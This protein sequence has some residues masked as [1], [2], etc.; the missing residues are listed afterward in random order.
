[1]E[2]HILRGVLRGG[3]NK[4][5]DGKRRSEKKEKTLTS[6]DE[7]IS[8]KGISPRLGIKLIY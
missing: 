4:G 2:E 7:T 5:K 8:R 1:V 3:E 6:T